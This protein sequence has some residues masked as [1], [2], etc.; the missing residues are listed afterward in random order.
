MEQFYWLGTFLWRVLLSSNRSMDLGRR[1]VVKNLGDNVARC[2]LR[3][4]RRFWSCAHGGWRGWFD[5]GDGA[6]AAK[7]EEEA[8]RLA[9]ETAGGG[10]GE[11]G[12]DEEVV[13]VFSVNL[14]GDSGMVAG[15]A[16][17]AEN[18]ALVGGGPHEAEDGS[19]DRGVGGAQIVE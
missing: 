13:D 11:V 16:G 10:E 8:C 14:A 17:V 12:R 7:M 1:M 9:R 4:L 5:R 19:V 2:W 6:R 3:R 18:S 15:R